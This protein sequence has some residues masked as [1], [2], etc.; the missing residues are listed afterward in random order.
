MSHARGYSLIELFRLTLSHSQAFPRVKVSRVESSLL[1]RYPLK[2]ATVLHHTVDHASSH[3]SVPCRYVEH[4]ESCKS[5]MKL[6]NAGSRKNVDHSRRTEKL[7]YHLRKYIKHRERFSTAGANCRARFLP[8]W[9]NHSQWNA[10]NS[11]WRQIASVVSCSFSVGGI[12]SKT[13]S[14]SSRGNAQ[15]TSKYWHHRGKVRRLIF[16]IARFQL[17]TNK[18][19]IQSKF[20]S[21]AKRIIR[22]RTKATPVKF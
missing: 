13:T 8:L 2:T 22:Q 16:K 10:N 21:F 19:F 4:F 1:I 14:C 9:A 7:R 17:L 5:T 12:K 6:H 11:A 15:R 3:A 18:K 20:R